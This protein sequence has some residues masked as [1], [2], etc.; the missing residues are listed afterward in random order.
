MSM[1]LLI[2]ALAI[3]ANFLLVL[4]AGKLVVAM[5]AAQPD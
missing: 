2:E 4:T 3:A 1:G 5:R